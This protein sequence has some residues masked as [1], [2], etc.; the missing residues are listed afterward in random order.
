[1]NI[2]DYGKEPNI[3]DEMISYLCYCNFVHDFTDLCSDDA[4][5][6]DFKVHE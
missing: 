4:I 3:L 5:L 6:G 2:Q 1:M